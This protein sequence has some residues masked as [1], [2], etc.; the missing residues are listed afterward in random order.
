MSGLIQD[1]LGLGLT[2]LSTLIARLSNVGWGHH[3]CGATTILASESSN[4]GGLSND[5]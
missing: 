3:P 4:G 2:I 5:N 1:A